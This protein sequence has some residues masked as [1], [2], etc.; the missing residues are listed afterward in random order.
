MYCSQV[1]IITVF[2]FAIYVRYLTT[3]FIAAEIFSRRKRTLLKKMFRQSECA[4]KKQKE[5]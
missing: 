3:I 2:S 4:H 5:D 1:I